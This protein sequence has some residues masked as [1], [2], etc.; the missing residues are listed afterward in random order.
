MLLLVLFLLKKLFKQTLSHL[1]LE[2]TLEVVF[3]PNFLVLL[4]RHGRSELLPIIP[5][6]PGRTASNTTEPCSSTRLCKIPQ[7]VFVR[8]LGVGDTCPQ[9]GL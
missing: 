8:W 4:L 3:R 2:Q 7:P 1:F 5:R 9:G 6:P